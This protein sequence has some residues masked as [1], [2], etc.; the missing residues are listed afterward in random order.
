M[1]VFTVALRDFKGPRL[2]EKNTKQVADK[3]IIAVNSVLKSLAT[4]W[5]LVSQLLHEKHVQSDVMSIVAY[6]WVAKKTEDI[7]STQKRNIHCQKGP[8]RS[9]TI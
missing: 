9:K 1:P 4:P 6:M 5:S 8:G 7:L 2:K 3:N